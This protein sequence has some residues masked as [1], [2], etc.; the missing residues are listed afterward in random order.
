MKKIFIIVTFAT[1]FCQVALAQ[2]KET[3]KKKEVS[4][5]EFDLE[6]LVGAD[7]TQ[8]LK[9]NYAASQSRQSISTATK[10]ATRMDNIPTITEVIS[11]QQIEQRGYR[12]LADVLNDLSDNH[13][14]RS[15]WGIG[16]PL[17]QN[18]GFG[19]RFD[20]G[21]NILILF[22]GQRLNGF[23]YGAR[24]GGEEYLL[25]NIDHIE[26]IRGGGSSLYGPNAFTCVVNL[27]S[28][29][30]LSDGKTSSFDAGVAGNFSAGGII[31]HASGIGKIGKVGT[32]SGSMRYMKEE[33]QSLLVQ[34]NL[35][36]DAK[37]K[38][39]VSGAFDAELFYKNKG[40]RVYSKVTDQSRNTFTGF[41]GVTP[42]NLPQG[43]LSTFAYSLGTD[44]TLKVSAKSE[45]KFQGGWHRDNWREVALVPIFQ[46]NAAGN[47]LLRDSQGNPIL[48]NISITRN[49]E[50][51]TTPFL[52]DGQGATTESIDGEIQFTYKYNGFNNIVSGVYVNYDKIVSAERPT[53]IELSPAVNFVPFQTYNDPANNWL[54]DLSATRL[55][56]GVY[57]QI[58]YE[59]SK[60]FLLNAGA[61]LDLFSGTGLLNQSY[62]SFNP[63]GGLI[64]INRETGN[65]KLMYGQ[66]FRAPN[67]VEALSSVTILGSPLNRPEQISMTQF[68]WAKN[69]GRKVRTELGGFYTEVSNALRT[70]AN[71]SEAL[72]AQAYVGQF[73]NVPGNEKTKS[74]GIDGKF[75]YTVEKL[76]F[77]MN[78][79]RLI[80]TNNGSGQRI[81]YIPLTMVNLK[82]NIP[83]KSWFNMN[84]GANY[85][86]D[87]TKADNDGRAPINNYLLLN[88]KL[89]ARLNNVPVEFSLSGRNLLNTDIR[90]PSSS[91]SFT[92]NFPA[93]GTEI[94]AGVVYRIK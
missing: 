47:A 22:N 19:L 30:E 6:D 73:V 48:D 31:T 64:Y 8:A 79:T 9:K 66:A 13:Q 86:G 85:R 56:T 29:V 78:F 42:T 38:D 59:I 32:L 90:Y 50:N 67:G 54:F 18:V 39:G 55:N 49:G 41:N 63:R 72:Q 81:A 80:D 62:S 57:T 10:V 52:I 23:L 3:E 61:R 7:T 1:L 37:L 84:V 83:V 27:I 71:I 28:R 44:Y 60:R 43:K 33:G 45:F 51:I 69:L 70:D 4:A 20:T 35:F 16:E 87:F 89:I 2:E 53:E 15:N 92:N 58:D 25:T 65:F 93:R 5:E 82:I 91:T 94:I 34:N 68:Q 75:T 17:N 24:F 40:F 77:E 36:G 88:A 46:I 76:D 26:I 12:H 74:V 21:Q 11:A 14:D